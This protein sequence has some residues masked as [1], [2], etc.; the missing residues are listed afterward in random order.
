MGRPGNALFR[1]VLILTFVFI[2]CIGGYFFFVFGKRPFLDS[3]HGPG[4]NR[5][6]EARAISGREL[7]AG[8][9]AG[10]HGEKGDGKGPAARFLY[11]RPRDFGEAKFRLVS[12]SNMLPSD[13]DLKRVIRNGMPGSAMFAFEHLGDE[14]VQELVKQVRVLIRQGIEDR[15]K[16]SA[17]ASGEKLDPAALAESLDELTRPGEP[18]SVPNQFSAATKESIARGGELFRDTKAACSACHGPLG[19][20]DGSQN[21]RND[22][23]M[24]TRP[25]DLTRGIF[26]SG[27]D[28]KQ[29][30]LRIVRGLPG[31]PMSSNRVLKPEEIGD[32]INYI[33][34][35]SPPEA[36]ALTQHRRRSLTARRVEAL[37]AGIEDAAWQDGQAVHIVVTPLWWRDYPEPD[38]KVSALHD[39]KTLAIRLS[40][41]DPTQNN[42]A[43]RPQ[44]FEDMAAVQLYKGSPEPFLGMGALDK[45][46][47]VWLWRAG[48]S[49]KPGEAPDVD[50]VYPNMAVDYYPFEKKGDGKRP[51]A[52]DRQDKGFLTADAAG[53]ALAD[54]A[55]ALTAGNLAAKGFG[56]LTMRSRASQAVAAGAFRK[57]GR[58]TVVLR[59]PLDA[60]AGNGLALAPADKISIAFALWDGEAR[61]RNGQK[62]VSIWHDLLLEK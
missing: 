2:V 28:P 21:Q 24:P 18:V 23:G 5:D 25:R 22:D 59:R 31:S 16:Q 43:V 13:D 34:S 40:W 7:Y 27:R 50:S 60:G 29:I 47:D 52:T 56:T 15:L 20:G 39:G 46:L 36:T 55:R 9:C 38:L 57:E 42:H 49:G 41:Y 61:D 62:L 6:A 54:P 11:P 44:D 4:S 14:A 10:C 12:T 26:K 53:N 58:W 37:P 45:T 19:K 51:H 3:G 33:L 48:W 35:L 17:A 32:V 1:V 30:Y 8:H